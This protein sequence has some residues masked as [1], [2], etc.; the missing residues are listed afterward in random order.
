[1]KSLRPIALGFGLLL[2]TAAAN[3]QGV[4]LRANIPFAFAV[5]NQAL[6]AGQY[7]IA[8]K[9]GNSAIL[10]VRS[11]DGN[12]AAS[13]ITY[14]F[15]GGNPSEKTELVF[16]NVG[17][18][19]VLSQI[20]VEGYSEGRQLLSSRAEEEVALDQKAD[21]VVIVAKLVNR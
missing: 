3:A 21:N 8:P 20:Q 2:A 15:G 16:H 1:M 14:S 17:K 7:V 10:I 5:G 13:A 9:V 4:T 18:Q 6:P 19:Y 11:S 12:R